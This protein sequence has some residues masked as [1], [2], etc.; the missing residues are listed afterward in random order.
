MARHSRL[1]LR[2]ALTGVCA[3]V[4]SGGNALEEML[5]LLQPPRAVKL[6]R[7]GLPY[8]RRVTVGLALWYCANTRWVGVSLRSAAMC[9][10]RA[11][12]G[13]LCTPSH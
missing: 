13:A 11:H 9:A 4:G 5:W 1:P 3:V 6:G 7:D 2:P 10:R 8:P 12:R